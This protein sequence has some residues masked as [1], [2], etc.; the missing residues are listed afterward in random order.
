LYNPSLK[1]EIT[2]SYELG[3]DLR[4]FKSRLLFDLAVYQNKSKNQIIAIPLDPTS[5]YSN[6]L[7]NAGL[8]ES[9]GIELQIK[10][11]P[12]LTRK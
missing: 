3:F 5:G 2:S 7:I 1:P 12:I 6:A 8:I 10:G 9:K 11:I 4:L